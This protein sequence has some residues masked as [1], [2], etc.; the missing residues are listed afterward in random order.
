MRGITQYYNSTIIIVMVIVCISFLTMCMNKKTAKADA[1]KK[2]SYKDFAGSASCQNCHKDIYH[3]HLNTAHFHTSEIASE[4]NIKGSFETGKN[5][6]PYPNG[7]FIAMKKMDS[8]FYQV[9]YFG[10]AERQRHSFNIVSGSGTKGQTYLY[11]EN[12]KLF[13]LPITYFTSASQWCNS[14][15]FP[16]RAVFK[17]PITS[18]CLECHTT[19]AAVISASGIE[20]EEFDK[21]TIVYGV[22]CERCHGPAAM[23]VAYQTQNPKDNN[24]KY[25]INPAKFTR[26]QNLD[27]CALCHGGK[28]QK[29]KSS[30]SFVSGDTLA[31]FFKWDTASKTAGDIDV[32]GNQLGLLKLSR[33]F[34][35]SSTLTCNSCH[36]PHQ[37]EKN[38]LAVYSQRCM[39]CHN[40]EHNNFCTI[41]PSLVANIKNNCI[42]C[43]LPKQASH[44]IS[45]F[46]PGQSM[47][48][49]SLIR[50]HYIT[51]YPDETKK[52]IEQMKKQS[53]ENK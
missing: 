6:F 47:L 46:L 13:Q 11:W 48:T 45:V 37:N 51:I 29:T 49:P 31:G 16:D 35:E 14:P 1:E 15:G 22:D 24:A 52:Y 23:H 32:H 2:A 34:L 9:E 3:S 28:L 7:S 5:I 38:E 27:L 18:R 39:T 25:I 40:K 50:T 41:N 10:N 30:F 8:G 21:K 53:R 33:C 20:P 19:F 44:A 12:N 26:Q 17:R 4:K 42:D 43:H 36:N